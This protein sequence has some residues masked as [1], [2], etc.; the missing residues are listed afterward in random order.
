LNH[1]DQ[2]SSC[3]E[4]HGSGTSGWS[5]EPANNA[6]PSGPALFQHSVG[7]AKMQPEPNKHT[8]RHAKANP[9]AERDTNADHIADT[10]IETNVGSLVLVGRAVK[11]FGL[12]FVSGIVVGAAS[13]YGYAVYK[14]LPYIKGKSEP[15]VQALVAPPAQTKTV[16]LHGLVRNSAD[17]PAKWF[18]V[19]VFA[20]QLGPVNNSDGSFRIEV[21]QSSSYNVAYWTDDGNVNVFHGN[22]AE[23]DGN[24]LKLQNVL[25]LLP[26]G[27]VTQTISSRRRVPNS[28]SQLARLES[29]GR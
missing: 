7:D 27:Q 2:T 8:R 5:P 20:N 25:R 19:G 11:R 29:N 6:A 14:P 1:D 22:P 17:E 4:T 26:K 28:R 13:M 23:Q 18:N 16:Q 10:L 15:V 21:P 3:T 12:K 9:N 24:G